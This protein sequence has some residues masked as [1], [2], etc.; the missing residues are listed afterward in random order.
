[1]VNTTER[2]PPAGSCCQF[3]EQEHKNMLS[4]KLM[5]IE[6][7]G[8]C[9]HRLFLQLM[10]VNWHMSKTGVKAMSH[11]RGRSGPVISKP[12][13]WRD[14]ALWKWGQPVF[15]QLGK[16]KTRV[17]WSVLTMAKPTSAFLRA[18]PS[19]VPS[20]VTATTC[21]WSTRVLSIIPARQ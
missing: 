12:L 7:A 9:W 20:P 8:W 21:R 3:D 5:K 16:N 15:E 18:G 17:V 2:K 4:S 11:T 14:C 13:R 6:I 10:Q 19:L 1:M